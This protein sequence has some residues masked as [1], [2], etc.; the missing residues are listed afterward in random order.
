LKTT[1]CNYIL[2]PLSKCV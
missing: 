2:Y 1:A